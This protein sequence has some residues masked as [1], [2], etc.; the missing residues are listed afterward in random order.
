MKKPLSCEPFVH[1]T[2]GADPGGCPEQ[3]PSVVIMPHGYN[4]HK[5]SLVLMPLKKLSINRSA[6]WGFATGCLCM[7]AFL[8]YTDR[9]RAVPMIGY[10]VEILGGAMAGAAVFSLLAWV[11]NLFVGTRG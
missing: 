2:T 8:L 10:A 1:A 9:A 11:S 4:F 3:P 5:G 7:A 6:T